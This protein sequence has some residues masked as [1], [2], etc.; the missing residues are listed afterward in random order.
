MVNIFY[1]DEDH[2]A[3]AR[4]MCDQH[5]L[6]IPMEVVQ[7]ACS[8]LAAIGPGVLAQ[9]K[10]EGVPRITNGRE[11]G[12]MRTLPRWAALCM[13]NY[14][15]VLLRG[16]AMV[17][18]YTLRYGRYHSMATA[19]AWLVCHPPDFNTPLWRQWMERESKGLDSK[20]RP[21]SAWFDAYGYLIGP[22]G[23]KRVYVWEME[24]RN[25]GACTHFAQIMDDDDFPGC[26]TPEEPVVAGRMH[27][28]M[29]AGATINGRRGS[30]LKESMRYF[31]R[32]PPAWLIE[33]GAQ[34]Q[35]VSVAKRPRPRT[36]FASEVSVK[37]SRMF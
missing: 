11:P 21:Y 28:A 8:V 24:D 15:E 23:E 4:A 12:H 27:Y 20:K 7:V 36:H 1:L 30:P 22:K 14:M 5:I 17:A 16:E 18:E 3:S 35:C 2:E 9:A 6:K 34:V 32:P 29:K 26:R 10:R 13:G 19:L 37:R 31:Y 33:T 25:D